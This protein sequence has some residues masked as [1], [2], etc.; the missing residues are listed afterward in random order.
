[1]ILL[2]TSGIAGE[3]TEQKLLRTSLL[4]GQSNMAGWGG[5][6][7]IDKGWANRRE[8]NDRIHFRSKE[9]GLQVAHLQPNR[10]PTDRPYKVKETFGLEY[11]FIDSI[12]KKISNEDILFLK[13]AVGGTTRC[14]AWNQEWT[15]A[16]SRKVKEDKAGVIN[17]GKTL[18]EKSNQSEQSPA[19]DS[20]QA[21]SEES[22]YLALLLI[23]FQK[24]R[25]L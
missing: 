16:K 1:M 14:G 3:K 7:S 9:T 10:R 24:R 15:L 13:H 5:Y 23:G 21:A 8:C 19:C 6:S 25:V 20:L 12:R 22:F 18:A 11:S 4:L 2:S 17:I